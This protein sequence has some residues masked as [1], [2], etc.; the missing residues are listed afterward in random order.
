MILYHGTSFR[1][2]E[3]IM[4]DGVMPR[5]K[6]GHKGTWESPLFAS[7]PDRVYLTRCFAMYYASSASKDGD[8]GLILEID[9]D[10]LDT[11]MLVPDEDAIIQSH[12][13]MPNDKS[14]LKKLSGPAA[15]KMAITMAGAQIGLGA[16]VASLKAIGGCAHVGVIPPSAITK[17]VRLDYNKMPGWWIGMIDTSAS[18]LSHMVSG[19]VFAEGLSYIMGDT[20]TITDRYAQVRSSAPGLPPHDPHPNR[21]SVE[22]LYNLATA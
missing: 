16:W 19:D 20:D 15:R 17:A 14:P 12:S 22:L 7:A 10:L 6:L 5:G 2:Y 13:I 3:S 4:R 21:G 18:V 1:H 9:T 8:D 11:S